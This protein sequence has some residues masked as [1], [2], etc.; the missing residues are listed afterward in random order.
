MEIKYIKY[1]KYGSCLHA[2]V[3]L[4]EETIN[5]KRFCGKPFLYLVTWEKNNIISTIL[6]VGDLDDYDYY[7]EFKNVTPGF[8]HELINWL[9]DHEYAKVR[10]FSDVDDFINGYFKVES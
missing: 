9:K 1:P 6:G 4:F 3:P 10:D 7:T 5:N 2:Q 8:V